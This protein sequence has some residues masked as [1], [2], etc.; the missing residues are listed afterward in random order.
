MTSPSSGMWLDPDRAAAAGQDLA[1]A[2]RQLG[3]LRDGMGNEMA[4]LSGARPWGSDDIG[5]TFERN[6]RPAE[7]Q[8]LR[9]WTLL[10]Q[11]VEGLGAEV[12]QAVRDAV[13]ADDRSGVRVRHT[14]GERS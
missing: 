5:S 2:G 4:A 8:F 14:Y 3:E 9:A 1:A 11:H 10:A 7:E 6:Y 13:D 12:V